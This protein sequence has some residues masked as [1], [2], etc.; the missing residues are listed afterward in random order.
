MQSSNAMNPV[1]TT[2][3]LGGRYEPGD[4][5]IAARAKPG[6]SRAPDKETFAGSDMSRARGIF[7]S[8]FL[9]AFWLQIAFGLRAQFT[10]ETNSNTLTITGYS[11]D[12]GILT[13]PET[14]GG[15]P[16]AA[17]GGGAFSGR[18]DLTG[19][20][21]PNTLTSIGDSA[22]QGCFALTNLALGD[23][24]VSIGKYAFFN[25][26]GLT[27]VTIPNSVITIGDGAFDSC[28]GLTSISV[29]PGNRSY[30]SI[31]GIL[32]DKSQSVLI[33]YPAKQGGSYTIPTS[34]TRIEDGAFES[35]VLTNL[36][37][38]DSVA[39]I[40]GNAFFY[41]RLRYVTIGRSVTNIGYA[42]FAGCGGLT[43]FLVD[44]ANPSFSSLGGLLLD[45]SHSVLIRYPPDLSDP[46][47]SLIPDGV[48]S[49][50]D[51]AFDSYTDLID[52]TIPDGVT[53]IGDHVFEGCSG[54]K[55]VTIPS[56]VTHLGDYAFQY[57]Y[58]LANILFEG[59]QP[60]E[61][62]GLF[63][64]STPTV[65][66]RAGAIGWGAVYAGRPA[67]LW[68]PTGLI[69]TANNES[70]TI[71]G[72]YG[73]GSDL[74]IPATLDGLPVVAVETGAFSN[75]FDLT[76]VIIPNSLKRIGDDA[77]Y[78]CQGLTKVTIPEGVTNIGDGAFAH[79][80]GLISVFIPSSVIHIGDVAFES[81]S[82]L[83]S[84]SVDKE[85]KSFKSTMGILFNNDETVLIQYPP[86]LGGSGTFSIPSSVTSI[87]R[88]AF[89]GCLKLTSVTIPN[90][91]KE[92]GHEAFYGCKALADLAIPNSVTNIGIGAF[93]SCYV[94]SSVRIPDSV[95]SLEDFSFIY[96]YSLSNVSLGSG[97]TTL[98]FGLFANCSS[99]TSINI[100]DNVTRIE[101]Q[102]F[103]NC[104]WLTSVTIGNGVT[105][106]GDNA[107][108]GCFS[109]ETIDIPKSVNRI[110]AVAFAFCPHL[111]NVTIGAGV[112]SIGDLVFLNCSRLAT[113]TF[114]GN[115]AVE[116]VGF[117]FG[118]SPTVYFLPQSHGWSPTYAG[119]PA[120]LWNPTV[121]LS[122]SSFGVRNGS[123]GFDI[124]GTPG[125]KVVIEA[126]TD[127]ANG[128]WT[129]VGT[130]TLTAD[131]SSFFEKHSQSNGNA[132]Y[133]LRTP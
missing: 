4:L 47:A 12:A 22:F 58:S 56:S 8:L 89:A 114:E 132:F 69:Y 127:L 94:L 90:S 7:G 95:A 106:I 97:V 26:S 64:G 2:M 41:S 55:R 87:G 133:R 36:T 24:I 1:T 35:C 119:R 76:S 111:E 59:N 68:N 115:P 62:V 74:T 50:G 43:R 30:T 112:T 70:I 33:K 120:L 45:K 18:M 124:H 79:C 78:G 49:V 40:G 126:S 60:P 96:C 128:P 44:E 113:V 81:C 123:F 130:N 84:I 110:G 129:S 72:Y 20:S 101:N 122:D 17:I 85:N 91:V 14:I 65:L 5:R 34:V 61:P 27:S 71:V 6:N 37:I 121:S 29:D 73:S 67:F 48:R 98:G 83:T 116:S 13:I 32:F 11:G 88:S 57:C 109:L 77:F 28:D 125:I 39:S 118:A 66:Y 31:G 52:V 46:G 16:V 105:T 93:N 86:L 23:S 80:S 131:G 63:L 9:C 53:N 117:S 108:A 51:Y 92:I 75:R 25:C 102:A 104:S 19:L 15:F 54:L 10:Y 103:E 82:G 3:D 38:G 107:F 21:I 42:A 100:P 99:L